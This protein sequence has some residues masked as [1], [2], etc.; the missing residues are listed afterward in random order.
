MWIKDWAPGIS[1]PGLRNALKF[2]MTESLS[3]GVRSL[4]PQ[5]QREEAKHQN[6]D[7]HFEKPSTSEK[8]FGAETKQPSTIHPIPKSHLSSSIIGHF[9]TI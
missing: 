2:S 6:Q 7:S 3:S 9:M 8:I 4:P 5:L 1:L